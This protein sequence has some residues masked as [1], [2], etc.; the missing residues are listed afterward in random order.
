MDTHRET[1][2]EILDLY[3]RFQMFTLQKKDIMLEV[4]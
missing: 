2:C 3:T 4:A 1:H